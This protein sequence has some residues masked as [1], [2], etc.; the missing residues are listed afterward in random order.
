MSISIKQSTKRLLPYIGTL[1]AFYYIVPLAS[2]LGSH[3]ADSSILMYVLYI[4]NPAVAFIANMIYSMR[5][6]F[7]WYLPL[8]TG[9]LFAPGIP[10][11]YNQTAVIY[12]FS[13]IVLGFIGAAAG[14]SIRKN[15]GK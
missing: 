5:H 14:F 4:F 12:I 15:G 13:Y 3:T 10:I 6:G 2:L 7:A 8:L 9:A 11:F 1:A